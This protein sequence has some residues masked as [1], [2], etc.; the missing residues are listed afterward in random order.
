[1]T[2]KQSFAFQTSLIYVFQTNTFY[3]ESSPAETRFVL[4]YKF[5]LCSNRNDLLWYDLQLQYI[6]IH[7]DH[8]NQD[9]QKR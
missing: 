1:V 6:G 3:I 4:L 7:W 2:P 8:W 5:F 9:K